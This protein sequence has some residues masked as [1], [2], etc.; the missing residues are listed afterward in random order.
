MDKQDYR[1]RR[2]D[3]KRGQGDSLPM[4][5]LA[6]Y[7]ELDH[8]RGKCGAKQ[9]G[10]D[11][12]SNVEM[13]MTKKGLA[14]YPRRMRRQ[15]V[16]AKAVIITGY[17]REKLEPKYVEKRF[18]AKGVISSPNPRNPRYQGPSHPALQTNHQRMTAELAE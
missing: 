2:K 16:A 11:R 10:Q 1:D 17:D 7:T 5:P 6:A 18:T 15:R 13:R 4:P 14:A 8:E 9:V 3:G 12:T